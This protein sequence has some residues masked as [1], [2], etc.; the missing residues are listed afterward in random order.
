MFGS[1]HFLRPWW[2]LAIIPAVI[3]FIIA[4][5]EIQ[6][7]YNSWAKHCDPHLLPHLIIGNDSA[8]KNVFPSFILSLWL[9]AIV[10]LAGPTWSFYAQPVYQKNIA[11][12][13]ALD[14]S[15]SMNADDISPS[16]LQRA[17]YKVLD[18]LKDIKEGQTGMIVFS[19]EP[20]I[21]SPLTADSNTIASQ[22]PVLD[23]TIV[24]VQGSDISKALTKSA[25]LLNQAGFTQG[26]IV[27]VT[28]STPSTED[29]NTSRK[30]AHEG[31]ETSVLAVGTEQ[32]GP[33]TD[34][35]GSF[36]TDNSGNAV[37]A[38]LDGAELEKLA[39][40]GT[41]SYVPF[42]D[43]DS[44]LKQILSTSNLSE[45]KNEPSKEIETKT[46]WKDEGYWFI[47]VLLIL[48]AFIAR[49]GWLEKI[50]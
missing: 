42:S 5:R 18:M 11:R 24:P 20:F 35:N 43:N 13:I 47:W 48:S 50:C 31:Y 49:R 17:K 9:I 25:D 16:R 22:V 6:S 37:L 14:V 44:D 8:K 39:I 12:V 2:F 1:F 15:Q 30:L 7:S 46:L 29:I 21:V 27:L 45:L 4:L 38:K 23:S 33:V 10:A 40:A 26:Q 36:V 28:D 19:S 3:L 41:G 34:G 32:G